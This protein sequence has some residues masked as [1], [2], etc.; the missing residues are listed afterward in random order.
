M[1]SW[2]KLHLGHEILNINRIIHY[3]GHYLTY[4]ISLGLDFSFITVWKKLLELNFIDIFASIF[5]LILEKR[6]NCC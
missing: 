4:V 6:N 5:F 1:N 3:H 2:F